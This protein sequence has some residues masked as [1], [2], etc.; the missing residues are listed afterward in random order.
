MNDNGADLELRLVRYFTVVAEHRNFGRA[1]AEL[2]VAQPA[3][4]RQ[5]QRLENR[6]GVLL[7]DRVPHGA[8]LTDAGRAFLPEAH[9][10]LRAAHRATLTARAHAPAG[11]VAVGY[12]EDL[13]VTPA[14]RE[15]RRRHPQAT[16]GTRH[17]ECR[18]E[19]MFADGTVDVVVAR[20]PLP[21]PA[22]DLRV[23]PLYEEPRMLV[24]PADH[25]LA[26][27]ASVSLQD[28]AGGLPVYC[29]HG[30]PRSIYP[31][32]VASLQTGPV[33]EGFEDRLELVA[34]GQAV[35]VLPVGDRRSSLRADLA[36]VPIDD[37][38][39]SEVVVVHRAGET[40][41]LV[42]EFVLV[43]Q[44]RLMPVPA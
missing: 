5:I 39:A 23:T 36:S 11:N 20:A 13:V 26:G 40:N 37:V 21:H 44:A 18:D 22:D 34:S 19:R 24:L 10:V 6:L 14:V 28:F 9:D 35:A 27:R 29:S 38:P 33:V 4:S 15:L 3:L 30:A 32:G 12:V 2:R 16:I 43:A 41:P 31:T 1:A 8:E 42:A 7:F 25:H 17:L